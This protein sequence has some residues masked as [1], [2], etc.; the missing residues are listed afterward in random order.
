MRFRAFFFP[1]FLTKTPGIFDF[2][3]FPKPSHNA[4]GAFAADETSAASAAAPQAERLSL[5]WTFAFP[6]ATLADLPPPDVLAATLAALA[7]PAP[8]PAP[9]AASTPRVNTLPTSPAKS[10]ARATGAVFTAPEAATAAAANLAS[11]SPVPKRHRGEA[12]PAA[13][14]ADDERAAAAAAAAA[15]AVDAAPAADNKPPTPKRARRLSARA[16]DALL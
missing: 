4:T 5:F 3:L 12:E 11:V 7:P 10:T 15:A 14:P 9:A 8:T 13:D 16:R 1:L 6:R 2:F